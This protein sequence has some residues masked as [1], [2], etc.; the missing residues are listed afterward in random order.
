MVIIV[1][2]GLLFLKSVIVIVLFLECR[3]LL[4]KT[5]LLTQII[6][7][8]VHEEQEGSDY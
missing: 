8:K 5:E 4:L 2:V 1:L 3:S 7:E 6:E